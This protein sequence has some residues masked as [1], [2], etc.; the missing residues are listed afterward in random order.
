MLV[1]RRIPAFAQ[2]ASPGRDAVIDGAQ[3]H[4]I[5]L[6]L[7]C[8]DHCATLISQPDAPVPEASETLIAQLGAY[9]GRDRSHHVVPEADA[10]NAPATSAWNISVRFGKD[11]LRNGMD[12]ASFIRYLG[13]L[14]TIESLETDWDAMP[15]AAE[16]DPES[17][18]LAVRIVFRGSVD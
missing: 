7:S 8:G 3:Q 6:L 2:V 16:M 4:L 14:G 13:T 9:L 18:Y 10:A 1:V 17:C 11:V 12:P 5:A 15:P